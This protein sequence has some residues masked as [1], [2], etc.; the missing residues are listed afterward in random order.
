MYVIDLIVDMFI[1]IRNVNNVC[2][3]VVDILVFKMKKVIVQILLEE[4]FIKDYEIIDDGKNGIIRIRLKYGLNKERVIIGFKRI[5]KLGRRVYVGK[6]EFLR[7]LGGFGIVI[8]FILKGIMID[9]K[10]RKEGVGG[11]VFCYVW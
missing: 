4:G 11:E 8:I 10:V 6:D 9:K 3:E 1:C 5:L 7:V 2:Y